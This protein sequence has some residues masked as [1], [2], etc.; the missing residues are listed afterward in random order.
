L[1]L[2]FY[3]EKAARIALPVCL[4]QVIFPRTLAAICEACQGYLKSLVPLTLSHPAILRTGSASDRVLTWDYPGLPKS[5]SE[6]R[7]QA[8]KDKHSKLVY[9]AS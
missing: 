1:L 6:F 5:K 4:D 2:E 8:V 7:L 9:E 3:I